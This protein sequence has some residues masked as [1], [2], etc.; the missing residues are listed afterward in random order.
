MSQ[1]QGG[2]AG[3]AELQK[4]CA[5]L[6]APCCVGCSLSLR[7]EQSSLPTF[8]P[9]GGLRAFLA[10]AP[11]FPPLSVNTHPPAAHSCPT[12]SS[13]FTTTGEAQRTH[14]HRAG[15]RHPLQ[16]GT[17]QIQAKDTCCR[18]WDMP[19]QRDSRP[20]ATQQRTF[21]YFICE[22]L[23]LNDGSGTTSNSGPLGLLVMSGQ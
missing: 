6:R 7:L 15:E 23:W 20:A 14:G 22:A 1:V 13:R 18:E 8:P 2:G 5:E 11:R 10:G 9:L 4:E 21:T 16:A 17:L 12:Q 3:D 19:Q